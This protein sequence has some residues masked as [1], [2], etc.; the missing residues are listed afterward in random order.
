MYIA[1]GIILFIIFIFLSI[2]HFYWGLG[3]RWGADAAIPTKVDSEKVLNPKMP[4]CFFVGFVL[5]CFA[6]FSLAR[7][8][9]LFSFLPG[10]LLKYG[11]WA[12]VIIFLFRAIGEFKYV[13]FFKKIKSTTFGQLDT[14]YFSPLCL[15]I[16]VL[17]LLL[18]LLK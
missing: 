2:L 5:L 15:L 3:G 17:A 11:L 4:E 16:A 1:T 18:L 8:T 9:V 10:W 13:G 12:I 6:V 14:K 7:A